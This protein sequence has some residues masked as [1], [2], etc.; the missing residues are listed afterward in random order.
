M[1]IATDLFKAGQGTLDLGGS[2]SNSYQGDTYIDE[3]TISL[4]KQ[5]AF[6]N[7]VQMLTLIDHV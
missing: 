7:E 6:T 1:D 2:A 5:D 3:G 4:N